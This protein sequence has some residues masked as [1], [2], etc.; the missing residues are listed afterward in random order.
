MCYDVDNAQKDKGDCRLN[1]YNF[2][3]G[4]SASH[5]KTGACPNP[6]HDI[7][8]CQITFAIDYRSALLFAP[9]YKISP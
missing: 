3:L 9:P 2:N 5:N 6:P 4:T 1:S 8:I 7:F